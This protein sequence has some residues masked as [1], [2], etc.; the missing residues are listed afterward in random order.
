MS[1]S[2]QLTT[3]PNPKYAGLPS[4]QDYYERFRN[5]NL[6]ISNNANPFLISPYAP[7]QLS[8]TTANAI[9]STNT[10]KPLTPGGTIQIQGDV[11]VAA[12]YQLFL[13]GNPFRTDRIY[14]GT[15]LGTPAQI[16]CST[17]PDVQVELAGNTNVVFQPSVATFENVTAPGTYSLFVGGTIST[18]NIAV[19]TAAGAAP[20]GL[21]VASLPITVGGVAY[22]LALY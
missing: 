2:S 14:A 19:T 16:I 21:P 6:F 20:G 5:P 4:V 3:A 10:I 12:P 1:A 22:N 15:S 11:N 18:A 8:Q 13:D 7:N 9:V 17:A